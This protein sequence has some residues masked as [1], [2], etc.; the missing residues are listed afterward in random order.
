VSNN[1]SAYLA[2]FNMIGGELLASVLEIRHSVGLSDT[3]RHETKGDKVNRD[4][5]H[6]VAMAQLDAEL[7]HREQQLTP[8]QRREDAERRLRDLEAR[9]AAAALDDKPE[10]NG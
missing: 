3:G 10:T 5:E 7:R 1:I 6:R 9:I 4:W 2:D 8:E